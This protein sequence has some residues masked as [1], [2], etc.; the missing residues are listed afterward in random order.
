[1]AKRLNQDGREAV[2]EFIRSNLT[3]PAALAPIYNLIEEKIRTHSG[4]DPIALQLSGMQ[5]NTGNEETLYI[6]PEWVIEDEPYWN[7]EIDCPYR[8]PKQHLY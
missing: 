1:M 6:K 8:L 4:S 3:G 2:A 7:K 5:T